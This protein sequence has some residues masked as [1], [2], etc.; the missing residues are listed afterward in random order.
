MVQEKRRSLESQLARAHWHKSSHSDGDGDSV[1]IADRTQIGT[2]R[3]SRDL[4]WA[5]AG[6]ESRGV[7]QLPCQDHS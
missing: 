2:A 6:V 4:G 1:E 5:G 7:D 3:D